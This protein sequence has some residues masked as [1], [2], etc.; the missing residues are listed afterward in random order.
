[1]NPIFPS[2]LSTNYFDLESKLGVLQRQGID[3]IHLDI[4][5][6]HFVDNIT[7]GPAILSAIKSRFPFRF[8]SH[9]MVSQP[10]RIIPLFMQAGSE[11]ISFHLE[12]ADGIEENIG[13]IKAGGRSAGLTLNPDT[14]V[15]RV[16][17]YLERLDYVLLMSVFPGRG[18][19]AFIEESLERVRR[20]KAE[21][22]RRSTRCLIQVDGGVNAANIALLRRCGC[23]LFVVGTYLYNATDIADTLAKLLGQLT[24]SKP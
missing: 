18:G 1:M 12:T 21:I 20:L 2:I 11:W 24:G 19:Q 6:G 8:D 3:F 22:E 4:M 17:P 7:Y 15:E 9:L 14:P 13:L 10:Q 5:D 23:D 16:F